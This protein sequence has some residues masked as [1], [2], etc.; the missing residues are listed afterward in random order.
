MENLELLH[1]KERFLKNGY[2]TIPI[3][4]ID[5]EFYNLLYEN[6]LCNNEK[7]LKSLFKTFRFDS[8]K[9]QTRIS[10]ENLSFDDL[11]LEKEKLYLQ[12]KDD[13]ISQIWFMNN[14]LRE[15]SHLKNKIKTALNK[16]VKFL[17][18]LDEKENII[19]PELQ[20]TYYNKNCRF[21]PHTDGP[22]SGIQCSMILYLNENYNREDGGLLVFNDELITPEFGICAI[23]DLTKFDIKHGVTEVV[24]GNGR[25]AILSF[26]K[27][28]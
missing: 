10:N 28:D 27:I 1:I 13:G 3:K 7:D 12:Y 26:P 9:F 17:Y 15:I 20:L 11:N 24:N 19:H 6:L 8:N 16:I 5:E 23:M 25:F 22:G 14:H 21:T 4:L 2:C 18:D